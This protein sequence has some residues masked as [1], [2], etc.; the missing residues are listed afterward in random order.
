MSKRFGMSK[1]LEE[2]ARKFWREGL[3]LNWYDDLGVVDNLIAIERKWVY[4]KRCCTAKLRGRKWK[5]R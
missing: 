5:G 2:Q 1:K 4:R 3:P